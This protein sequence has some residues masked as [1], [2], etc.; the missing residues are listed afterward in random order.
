MLLLEPTRFS[1]QPALAL[2]L[3]RLERRRLALLLELL[4]ASALLPPSVLP[5]F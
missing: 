4:L 5:A 1:L 2:E 3:L